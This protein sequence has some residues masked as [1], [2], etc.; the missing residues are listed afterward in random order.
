MIVD[1]D[2]DGIIRNNTEG[3]QVCNDNIPPAVQQSTIIIINFQ[4]L[5]NI[6]VVA[7][8]T[9]MSLVLMLPS[10]STSWCVRM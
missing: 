7:V 3:A 2:I 5:I 8:V 10:E 9:L 1:D 6:Y 4:I